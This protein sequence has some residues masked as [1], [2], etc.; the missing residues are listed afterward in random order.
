MRKLTLLSAFIMFLGSMQVDAQ[1]ILTLQDALNI[2]FENSSSLIQSQ[3]SLQQNELNLKA[4]EAS[5]KS[6]F[7]LDVN[8]F[9]YS[10]NRVYDSYNSVWYDS[11]TM[12]S[13]AS[14]GI[15][16]P[17]KWTDGTIALYN[18]FQW[19]DAS[20]V[21]SSQNNTSFSHDI[22]LRITQPI[23]TYNRTKIQLRELELS[24]ENARI[25]FALQQLSIEQSVTSNFYN[26]YQQQQS[27][28]IAQEE[29]KNQYQNYEIIRNKVEAGLVV[30]EELFQA[31]VNLATSESSINSQEMNYE[32]SKDNFKI[33][34]GMPLEEDFAVLP[35][36][37]VHAVFVN[38]IDAVKYA[39][40][41][42]LELRQRDIELERDL[43]S[44]T[45]AKAENEFS[46]SISARVGLNALGGKVG[47]MYD[48]PRDNE[49]IGVTLS[50]PIFDWG[51]R[52]AR[53][54]SSKLSLESDEINLDQQKREII[55]SVTQI[56]RSIPIRISQIEIARKGV[57]NAERAYDINMEK[58]RNGNL[59]GIELQ[60]YQTQLTS[61]RQ[62][63]TSAIIDYKTELLNLKIQSLWD[64]ETNKSY[65]PV[66]IL[67]SRR[68]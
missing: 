7:S 11:K 18:D 67:I 56:T 8:P 33:L 35:D 13:S 23:F 26:V 46:G 12:S 17:V 21:S 68:R 39:L 42:R 31:E 30:R 5:L 27:L 6:Q 22:S 64:F 53:I 28:I 41:Q 63:Y 44:I 29:Y 61:A 55:V 4:Q 36:T 60:Q 45:R 51:A 52:K 2:A 57:E 3:I 9:T 49:Q 47:N 25:S 37:S 24:L 34:L 54:R 65:L 20:N 19:Q 58:Y 32:N 38:P 10:R 40:D 50:I 66:D 48:H 43:F 14:L 59:T 62:Q 16:Q 1:R 15:V